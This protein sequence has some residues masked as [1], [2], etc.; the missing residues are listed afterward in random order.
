MY[1]NRQ[2]DAC[3]W[4]ADQQTDMAFITKDADVRYLT[5]MP[6]G[7]VL[8]LF[9]SGKSILLPWDLILADKI[10]DADEIIAYTD[11]SRDIRKALAGIA[12]REKLS[13]G[14]RVE[15]PAEVTHL[16]YGGFEEAL[17][18]FSVVCR[19]DGFSGYVRQARMV[20]DG[21]E[22]ALVKKACALT[23]TLIDEVEAG[24]ADG[25]LALEAD[26]AL[27]LELQS[28]KRGAEAM[29]FETIAAGPSRSFGIHAFPAFTAAG[30]GGPGMSILDFGVN[31]D[32]YTSDVT[33]S[34]LRG[35]MSD[36]QTKMISLVE[37]AYDLS[38]SMIRPGAGTCELAK[39]VEDLF[40]D[41]G[42]Q[43]PHALG[44]GI[45][46]EVHETPVF[47]ARPD[48][49]TL[50]EP[51]MVLAIEPGL[52]DQEAGGVRLENDF[53]VTDDGALVL[54]TSRLIRFPD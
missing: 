31:V 27:F 42:V 1:R 47:R 24:V 49:N 10:A 35:N 26:V 13:H 15:I 28:R 29:G 46:L 6:Y 20:K 34:F 43:M 51:G 48:S 9:A 44:H 8:V 33:V 19:E 39:A 23:N 5:G 11:Y 37:E 17:S 30:F 22:M 16:N 50:L 36:R 25:S 21:A 52:Y 18:D 41:A 3:R 32:G 45:G 7:S 54:T 40:A 12:E 38:T 2:K 14:S 4:L 53:L